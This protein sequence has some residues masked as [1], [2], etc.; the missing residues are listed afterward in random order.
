MPGHAGKSG[1][2][3]DNQ[4]EEGG[5]GPTTAR[6]QVLPKASM[7]RSCFTQQKETSIMSLHWMKYMGLRLKSLLSHNDLL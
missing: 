5:L 1:T 3:A 7:T 6:N 4:Q 2:S